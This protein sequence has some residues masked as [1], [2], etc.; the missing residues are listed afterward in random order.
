[1][2]PVAS[3]F[4]RGK[5]GFL[6]IAGGAE[7]GQ[8][9]RMRVLSLLCV[10]A[11]LSTRAKF[12]RFLRS[13][14]LCVSILGLTACQSLTVTERQQYDN[15]ISQGAEPI[16]KKDPAAAAF[17][18]VGPGLGD[19]YLEQWGVFWL[20]FLLWY[21]SVIWAVPQGYVSATNINMRE[22]V[23]H[24]TIGKGAGFGYD[25]NRYKSPA[26]SSTEEAGSDGLLDAVAPYQSSRPEQHSYDPSGR[27]HSTS[28]ERQIAVSG[29]AKDQRSSAQ[30]GGVADGWHHPAN[31]KRVE[32]GMSQFQV[33]SLLGHS[34]SVEDI[35]SFR[36]LFYRGEV[37]G[38]SVS[39][40]I[41]LESDRVWQINIP[42]F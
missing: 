25:I 5:L 21:P 27:R 12:R 40:N 34:T 13:F 14:A 23:V 32:K 35:S 30:P 7:L 42:V 39:G 6:V 22:T 28:V 33:V 26:I 10:D 2:Q 36:K 31:W 15:L 19:L 16:E 29:P 37:N 9:C 1:V 8:A 24:Y 11:L 17:L 20:D 41:K 4:L 3:Q 18:N 38:N